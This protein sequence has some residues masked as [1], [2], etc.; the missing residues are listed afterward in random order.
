[1]SV[2]KWY[3][4]QLRVFADE[5]LEAAF[6]DEYLSLT[7]ADARLVRDDF[8]EASET[9]GINAATYRQRIGKGNLHEYAKVMRAQAQ[10]EAT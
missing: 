9:E 10:R 2:R 4:A 8:L 6:V 5:S 3:P 7:V 1:M